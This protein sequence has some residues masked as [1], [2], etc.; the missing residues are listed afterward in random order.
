MHLISHN[1]EN[2]MLFSFGAQ[3]ILGTLVG[4]FKPSLVCFLF[5]YTI[6]QSVFSPGANRLC[7][8]FFVG[9]MVGNRSIH[10]RSWVSHALHGVNS[11]L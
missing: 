10:S 1:G 6:Y 5:V 2:V 7:V 3:V 8:I 9:Y 11:Y 4:I